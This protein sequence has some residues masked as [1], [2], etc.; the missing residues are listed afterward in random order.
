VSKTARQALGYKELFAH[1]AGQISLEEAVEEAI[2]RTRSFA[3]RQWSWFR[4]DPRIDWATDPERSVVA[5][6]AALGPRSASRLRN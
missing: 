1:L 6:D 4:R 5:L 2:R 3:R